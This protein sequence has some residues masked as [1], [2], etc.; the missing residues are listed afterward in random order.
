MLEEL[1]ASG[2]SRRRAWENLQEIRW[3]IKDA[4]G[5]ELPPPKRR[6]IDLEGQVVKDGARRVVRDHQTAL[7]DLVNAVH[8]VSGACRETTADLAR[9]RIRPRGA[10]IEQ[11]D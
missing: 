11:G 5:I 4:T 2:A 10:G 1:E 9:I 8:R 7:S 3:M 6:T